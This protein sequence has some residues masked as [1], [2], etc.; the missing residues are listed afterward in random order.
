MRRFSTANSSQLIHFSGPGGQRL[1]DKDVLAG[2]QNFP[3]KVE[4]SGGRRR[5][6]NRGDFRIIQNNVDG[7]D[8]TGAGEVCFHKGPPLGA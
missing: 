3:G 8:G 5:D 1:F 6:D 2:V 4:M 7:I